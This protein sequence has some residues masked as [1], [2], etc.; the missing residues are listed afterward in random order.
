MNGHI[1]EDISNVF[2]KSKIIRNDSKI[3]DVDDIT[4]SLFKLKILNTIDQIKQKKK[5]PP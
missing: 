5:D 2:S 1:E 3:D 4:L